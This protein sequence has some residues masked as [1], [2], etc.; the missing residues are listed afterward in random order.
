[1][2]GLLTF[3]LLGA[4]ATVGALAWLMKEARSPGPLAED[5]VVMIVRED[6]AA[7]IADQLERA[8]VIDSAMWFNILTLL[9]GNR[10]AL[11]RGEYA[12]KAGMSMND[13]ENELIAHRVVRYKLTIPEGLTSEQVVDRLREDTVLTG[14]VREPPR[15][16]SLMPD[17]YYFER[18]DTRQS[19]LSRMAKTQAKTVDEIWKQRSPD[20]PIKSPWEMV[21][22][23]SIVEKETGKPDER[24]RVAGVFV[25]R[26]E[27]H[28]RLG[29]DP[30]IVYGLAPGKGTLGRSITK[31]DLNQS[32]P[33]NTYVID[34]L[35]PGP[36]CNPGK[37]ALEAVAKPAR[38]KDLYFVADGTGGHAFAET[39]DQHQK[40]VARWRQIE[41]DVKDKLAPDVTPQPGPAIRGSIETVDPAQFGEL[42]TPGQGQAPASMLARLG[43][44]GSD[45]NTQEAALTSLA[46][47][48]VK[49]IKEMKAAATGAKAWPTKS[50]AVGDGDAPTAGLGA[51]VSVASTQFGSLAAPSQGQGAPASVI[52]R[53]S[54]IGADRNAKDAAL[55]SLADPGV[56]TIEELGVVVSGVNDAPAEGFAFGDD[57][58]RERARRTGRLRSALTGHA[59]GSE[60]ARGQIRNGDA[61][62]PPRSPTSL[63]A[64][65]TQVSPG[66]ASGTPAHLRRLRRHC[67][68]PSAQQDLRSELREG[69]AGR[70][71]VE[72]RLPAVAASSLTPDGKALMHERER[73][74]AGVRDIEALDRAGQ[75]EAGQTIASLARQPSQALVLRAEDQ[76]Q[77]A[78]ERLVREPVSAPRN[79]ARS[80]NSPCPPSRRAPA[81]DW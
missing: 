24:P 47:P 54:K 42:V 1:M 51:S 35:P 2:S 69:G 31:A 12:F 79:R 64:A 21:T 71:R 5:K 60:G 67:A 19:I 13:I 16:G 23:A 56:K 68:R 9:D 58:P 20:L 4:L 45:R 6:D 34:G 43:K 63:V 32:T 38:S 73:N 29:S 36:I 14:D 50:S 78:R 61:W 46:A 48:T 40:N 26:L 7:S 52:T 76:R 25:N 44:I 80:A 62:P 57:D 28:M 27:K 8:G 74:G 75:I 15:E 22:L 70:R 81:P 37:A 11:K 77:R 18:G 39:L 41:K 66:T 17:T 65:P 3:V 33:Y 55:A 10:G 59:R 53:L 49:T 30:T 72:V